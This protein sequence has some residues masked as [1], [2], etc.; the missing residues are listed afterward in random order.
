MLPGSIVVRSHEL[1]RGIYP[2]GFSKVRS[3]YVERGIGAIFQNEAVA[4]SARS[5]DL[6]RGVEPPAKV[7]D[8]RDTSDCVNFDGRARP[9][10]GTSRHRCVLPMGKIAS[11]ISRLP[12]WPSVA[13]ARSRS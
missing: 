9:P 12:D 3:G 1:A 7:A 4:S 5:H 2:V 13:A 6:A 10:F 11:L 8:E